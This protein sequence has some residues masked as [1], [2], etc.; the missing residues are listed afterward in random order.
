MFSSKQCLVLVAL[1]LAFSSIGANAQ[2]KPFDLHG[3]Y[4]EGC[5]CQ[6]VCSCDLLGGMVPGCHVMG[7]MIISSGNYGNA[8]LSGVK[9]AFAVAENWVRLYVQSKDSL[10]TKTIGDMVRAMFS[11][12]GEVESINDAKIDLSGSDGN[13]TLTV[14]DGEVLTL[15]TQPVLGADGKTAVTY[16]N[17]PDPLFHTIMQGKVVSASYHD[18]KHDFTLK[19]SN[20]F[21]NQDWSAS[22][23]I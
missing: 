21:F 22:G 15:K 14:N 5:T 2:E 6:V 7:A 8:D 4:L 10:Q 12:Y 9:L 11:D 18:D 3:I 1:V 17:Y 13:Y 23:K 16:T 19:D 20:S